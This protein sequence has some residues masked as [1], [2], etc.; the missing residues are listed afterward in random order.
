MQA[1][2]QLCEQPGWHIAAG[3]GGGGGGGGMIA[4]GKQHCGA[5]DG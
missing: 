3:G 2:A 4:G 1:G 5:H